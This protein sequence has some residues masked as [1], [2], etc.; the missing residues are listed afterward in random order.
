MRAA[1]NWQKIVAAAKDRWRVTPNPDARKFFNEIIAEGA[2]GRVFCWKGF[3]KWADVFQGMWAFRG[4]LDSEWDL[5]TSLSRATILSY[6]TELSTGVQRRAAAHEKWLLREFQRQAHHYLSDLP[7]H[8]QVVDWLALMQHY[9]APTRLLDWTRSPYVALYFAVEKSIPLAQ[10]RRSLAVQRSEIR[11]RREKPAAVWAIDCEWALRESAKSWGQFDPNLS[12]EALTARITGLLNERL[13]GQPQS[14][15]PCGIV[16]PVDPHFINERMAAQQGL[17]LCSTQ[18]DFPFDVALLNMIFKDE[19][20]ERSPIRKLIVRPEDR[21]R[22]L[23]ELKRMNITAASLFPELEGF[24]RSLAAELQIKM[25]EE[26]AAVE[27]QVA[28][29]DSLLTGAGADVARDVCVG[30]VQRNAIPLRAK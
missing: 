5:E 15:D 10:K 3:R 22:F 25:F 14:N 18:P 29:T 16:F 9:H 7:A 13:V 6:K 23:R 19:S 8:D 17:H 26:T 2:R 30:P 28:S 21:V 12:H 1:P 20:S 27:H 11:S 24:G 4:Q